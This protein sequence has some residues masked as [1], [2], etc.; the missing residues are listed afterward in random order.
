MVS[1]KLSSSRGFSLVDILMAIIIIGIGLLGTVEAFRINSKS[2]THSEIRCR[3]SLIGQS[4]ISYFQR[5]GY[6]GEDIHHSTEIPE[7]TG[8]DTYKG[9]EWDLT[10]TK[11]LASG[12][13]AN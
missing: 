13:Y 9:F 12:Y 11:R 8:I 10:K 4:L 6:P 2:I 3:A 1:H 5:E 7:A